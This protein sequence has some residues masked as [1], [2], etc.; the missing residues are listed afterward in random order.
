MEE[1]PAKGGGGGGGGG[2][3]Y[4][5]VGS[6]FDLS[7]VISNEN[8]RMKISLMCELSNFRANQPANL[9]RFCRHTRI[10]GTNQFLALCLL[11]LA[12]HRVEPYWSRWFS[13]GE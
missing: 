6:P 11:S 2:V 1:V 7:Q 9:C 4:L 10:H 5:V 12:S 13:S 3:A 8:P